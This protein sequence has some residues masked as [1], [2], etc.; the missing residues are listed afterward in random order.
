M[1]EM[2]DVEKSNMDKVIEKVQRLLNLASKNPNEHEA[3]SAAAK[4]QELLTAYNLDMAVLEQGNSGSGK[5]EDARIRGGAYQ[6]ERELWRKIAELNF[7]YYF[8]TR[9]RNKEKYRGR[10]WSFKHRIVGRVVNT[11]ATKV[12]GDYIQSTIERI[13]RERFP[14]ASQF[15]S[16]EAVAY[17]EGM[18][19]AVWHKLDVKRREMKKAEAAKAQK[20]E[21]DR[22]R[23]ARAG[24]SLATA[25]TIADVV[26]SEEIANYDFLHGEGAWDRKEKANAE[27]KKELAEHRAEQAKADREAEEEYTRWAAAHPEEAAKEAA[28]V[29]AQEKAKARAR[30][31]RGSSYRERRMTGREER[32]SSTY[33]HQGYDR[34][35]DIS[36]EPQMGDR[37]SET[38]RI[39]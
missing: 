33:F 34:G 29:R 3:A 37:K 21:E 24:V 7:C 19:D 1:T 14:Q 26:K 12:M 17:R 2:T 10:S 23:A 18:S 13:C 31:R 16:R 9:E 15:F 22:L 11:T 35:K 6:Y 38:K 39:K 25:L 20:E 28:K 36:I 8:V 30:E 5:R 27:W 4:A 32:E